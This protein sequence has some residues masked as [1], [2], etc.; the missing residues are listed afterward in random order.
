MISITTMV[1]I[2]MMM[3]RDD[4]DVDDNDMVTMMMMM[5]RDDYYCC[6][7]DG[8]DCDWW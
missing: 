3:I 7:N 8:N 6:Y 4:Y 1:M 5:I 2:V